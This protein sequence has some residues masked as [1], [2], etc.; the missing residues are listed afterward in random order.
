[1]TWGD[2]DWGGGGDSSA[3][4]D[5]LKNVRLQILGGHRCELLIA[6]G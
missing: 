5:Q 1:M 6:I 2:A 4:Q 3:V